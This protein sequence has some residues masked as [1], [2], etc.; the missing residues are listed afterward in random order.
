MGFQ[1]TLGMMALGA[2]LSSAPH[3]PALGQLTS[4]QNSPSGRWTGL[5]FLLKGAFVFIDSV[6]KAGKGSPGGKVSPTPTSQESEVGTKVCT[7]H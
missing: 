5:S 2:T 4:F 3:R 1:G 7:Q 6:H